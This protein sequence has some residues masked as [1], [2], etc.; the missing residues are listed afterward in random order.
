[1]SYHEP[2]YLPWAGRRVPITFLAGYLGAGK[3]TLL[4]ELLATAQRPIAVMVNDV[5]A[6]NIDARLIRRH[7]GAAIELTDGCVCCSLSG[8]FGAAF[9]A[10]RE[11][12]T[13]PDHVVVELSG[14]ADPTRVLPWSRT[15]GF[16]LDGVVAVVD[17][18][19]FLARMEEPIPAL[20]IERQ[21]EA[22]DLV[23]LSK[24]DITDPTTVS[25]VKAHI[26][27]LVP[28][29]PVIDKGTGT[30]R[31]L[32]QLG[33]RSA[34]AASSLPEPTL[35]DQHSTA[36]VPLPSPITRSDLSAILDR[37][38]SGTV[39]AKG[40]ALQPDGTALL[41]QVVGNRRTITELGRDEPAT[42]SDLVVVR[43][44]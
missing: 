13:P 26:A 41:I 1:M 44:Q 10:L 5:G 2:Q 25:L 23:L 11:R 16:M 38:G 22:A 3:T 31:A 28:A 15:A 8:G 35:F 6:V 4:N 30:S 27:R 37:L 33:G 12:G 7:D 14:V 20:T 40:I 43:V 19:Q 39:R 36:V 9:D 32:L 42:P 21:V 29:T 18:E 34:G 17:A 24:T